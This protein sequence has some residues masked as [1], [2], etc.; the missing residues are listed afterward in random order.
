MLLNVEDK[1]VFWQVR[2]VNPLINSEIEDSLEKISNG[3]SNADDF[4]NRVIMSYG[5]EFFEELSQ[6]DMLRNVTLFSAYQFLRR[7]GYR[8]LGYEYVKDRDRT[9][10]NS[11]ILSINISKLDSEVVLENALLNEAINDFFE[12]K[13]VVLNKAK[14]TFPFHLEGCIEKESAIKDVYM[15]Y[16]SFPLSGRFKERKIG[17]GQDGPLDRLI[18]GGVSLLSY[19]GYDTWSSC[20]G[21]VRYDEAGVEGACTPYILLQLDD[22]SYRKLIEVKESD[23]DFEVITVSPFL[24]SSGVVSFKIE[25]GCKVILD[26]TDSSERAVIL[27]YYLTVLN[28]YIY[29]LHC[30]L[31]SKS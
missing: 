15:D 14:S 27:S 28:K 12:Y 17:K 7:S 30:D 19:L 24:H 23:P 25:S 6:F 18:V 3:S 26:A 29:R 16:L 22:L 8:Y 2:V 9:S 5:V 21:H 1:G 13:E 4:A 20:A 11:G 10:I 31:V